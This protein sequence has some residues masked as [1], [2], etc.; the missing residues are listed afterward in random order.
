MRSFRWWSIGLVVM[1]AE[2]CCNN[3]NF[4]YVVIA[5]RI[6]QQHF[7]KN[8]NDNALLA[9]TRHTPLDTNNAAKKTK[10]SSSSY[11]QL[12]LAN[13]V[14]EN[15]VK[16]GIDAVV[17]ALRTDKVAN[18]ELGRLEKVTTILGYGIQPGSILALRFNASFKKSG[19]GSSSIPLPFGLGQSN[20]S[21]G[22]GSMVGQ[23]KATIDT[24]TNKV[25]TCTVFRDL[26]YGRAFNLKV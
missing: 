24:K 26:G 4:P 11:Q 25:T 3:Y 12:H 1:L 8:N 18:M 10:R 9:L 14:S 6:Q 15:E 13:T 17:K 19:K 5:F 2:R 7:D 22:R 16:T 21:E 23:V 20:V